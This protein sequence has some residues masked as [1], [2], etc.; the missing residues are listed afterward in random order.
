VEVDAE[1]DSLL[2]LCNWFHRMTQGVYDPTI[3]PLLRLWD[4][5]REDACPPE[6]DAVERAREA[7]GWAKVQRSPGRVYLPR[8]GMSLD[9][10]GI[11]KEYAVDRVVETLLAAG[12]R[13]V[14]ADFGRDVRVAGAAPEGG[15][16][17]IGL[18]DPADPGRCWCGLAVT[19]RAVATSGNYRRHFMWQGRQYGHILDPRT[20]YPVENG[21]LAATVVAP[22]CT[23]AGMLTT[24]AFIL[25]PAEGLDLIREAGLAEGC[26]VTETRRLATSG[27]QRYVTSGGSR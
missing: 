26:V 12:C 23:E 1:L 16:W 4:Y 11:G 17:R 8:E 25:G 15:P 18:E 3:G 24:A 27:F 7:V 20:G 19:D 9:L 13:S 21:C 10:G 6:P 5:H 22:T 2:T 14:L